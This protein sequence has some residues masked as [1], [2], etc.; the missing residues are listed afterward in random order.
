MVANDPPPLP[1]VI[2][3]LAIERTLTLLSGKE[4]EGKSL[5]SMGLA[6]GVALGENVAGFACA[7]HKV[8][9]VDAENGEYEIRRH[10]K[11]LGLPSE[12]IAFAEADGFHLA[13]D[14]SGLDA[15]IQ[16]E[17]P[18][19]VILDSFRSL[20][21]G[22]DENDSG[23]VA[24]VLDP[25]RNLLRRRGPAGILLH[26]VSRAGNEYRG[27]S[28]IGAAL[29]LGFRLSRHP[30]IQTPMSG[31]SCTALSAAPPPSPRIA[32]FACM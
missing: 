12:G 11:T 17:Q 20:W 31:D 3:G 6:T 23:A 7:P 5:L 8:L 9:I 21:P 29:E 10:V 28:A 32:G 22:G 18:A 1:W 25:L 2:E 27:T 13:N 30:G 24:A 26:H 19:L 14:L 4:G 16:Q 15:L